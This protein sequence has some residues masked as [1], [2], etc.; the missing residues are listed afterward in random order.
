LRTHC[1]CLPQEDVMKGGKFRVKEWT[2]R[3]YGADLGLNRHKKKN[4][5]VIPSTLKGEVCFAASA[6]EFIRF[7]REVNMLRE[8]VSERKHSQYP[9]N[10]TNL[11]KQ[12]MWTLIPTHAA[13]LYM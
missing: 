11:N 3:P 4:Q 8:V 13:N 10:K 9:V 1:G 2:L 5:V 7:T 6:V 12:R